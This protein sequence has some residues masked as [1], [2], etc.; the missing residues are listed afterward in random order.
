MALILLGMAGFGLAVLANN[1][2]SQTITVLTRKGVASHH[3]LSSSA[4]VAP[5]GTAVIAGP[6]AS[7]RSS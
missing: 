7:R 6:S 2:L 4:S 3:R 5:D 1:F